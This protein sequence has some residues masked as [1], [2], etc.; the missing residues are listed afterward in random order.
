MKRIL[1]SLIALFVA[2]SVAWA[3]A[4]YPTS[5]KV[6]T[7]KTTGETIAAAHVNDLQDEVVAIEQGLLNGF[8][9]DLKPDTDGG[10]ALGTT[11]LRFK[12]L[13]LFLGTLTD[14]LPAIDIAGTWNDA[15]DTFTGIKGNWADT[16]SAAASLLLDLQVGG[17]SKFKV[18][19]AGLATLAAG[20]TFAGPLLFSTDN[21]QD[22]GA[23]GAS[24]PRNVFAGTGFVFPYATGSKTTNSFNWGGNVGIYLSAG[25][26]FDGDVE[27]S[28][29]FF[30]VDGATKWEITSAA[31][32]LAGVDNTQD[33]GS[34][35]KRVRDIYVG[36]SVRIG[37]NPATSG[38]IR[39]LAGSSSIQG[40]NAANTVDLPFVEHE[41]VNNKVR[42]G[43]LDRTS[44]IR[45]D[46]TAPASANGEWWV[47]VTGTSPSRIAAIKVNDA[48]TVRTIASIT[49]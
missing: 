21:T 42:F 4:S 47:E 25:I 8:Q 41:E 26:H 49:F 39:L 10:R 31:H 7:T 1:P 43:N 30:Q 12:N 37:T 24:R 11:A 9:H 13:R 32:F 15:A 46:K 34:S 38:Q 20:L 23:S 16:L 14:P 28:G 18:D 5:V 6:F 35:A 29:F 19:K 45:T 33:I 17:V 3:A 2:V 44:V 27:N 22:I 36:T 40:R 48:G